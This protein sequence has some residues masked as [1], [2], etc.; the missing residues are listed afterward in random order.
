MTTYLAATGDVHAGSTLAPCGAEPVPL[1][2]G[3]SYTRSKP[4]EWVTERFEDYCQKVSKLRKKKGDRLV[5]LL[6]GDLVDGGAH[7]GT[8]QCIS[9]DLAVQRLVLERLSQPLIDSE[10]DAVI[11]VRGTPVH[12]GKS[13]GAE[14]SFAR[15]LSF[16]VPVLKHREVGTYSHYHYTGSIGGVRI[17]AAHHGRVG[18]RSWTRLSA[19]G[20]LATEVLVEYSIRDEP[21]PHLAIRSHCHLYADSGPSTKVRVLALPAWQLKTEYGHQKF[22][23][24][25]ADIGGAVIACDKGRYEI[26]THLY[27]PKRDKLWHPA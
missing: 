10:P 16:K 14:E 24:S 4:Q 1:D 25:L 15:W 17:D 13:G 19:V 3:G 9:G 27:Y 11:V 18:G 5:W 21:P 23:E 22:P 2:D 20:A 7:H 12:V 6:N 26:E 8:H